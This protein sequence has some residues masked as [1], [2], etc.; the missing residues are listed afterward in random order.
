M[1]RS[2]RSVCSA[3]LATLA[4]VALPTAADAATT[5][6]AVPENC[7]SK[8]VAP[9]TQTPVTAGPVL[10]AG[11]TAIRLC[12]YGPLPRLRLEAVHLTRSASV[13][14]RIVKQLNGLGSMPAG[15]YNCP[16][17][18]GAEVAL[19]V[20]YR[21]GAS[22][23]VTVDLGGCRDVTRG[24]VRRWAEPSPG[25]PALLADLVRLTP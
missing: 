6:S 4:V 2:W 23:T 14:G 18:T 8:W 9:S 13:I 17:D 16:A 19:L 22:A 12:R 15:T 24:P 25:G 3:S 20:R 21:S 11:V 7:P 1:T 5:R 10:S